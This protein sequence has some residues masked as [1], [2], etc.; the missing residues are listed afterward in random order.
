MFKWLR[1]LFRPKKPRCKSCKYKIDNRVGWFC[2][3]V[4]VAT[5]GPYKTYKGICGNK[6]VR[7]SPIWCPMKRK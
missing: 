2:R 4:W 6:I 5:N 3:K 7:T 1:Q